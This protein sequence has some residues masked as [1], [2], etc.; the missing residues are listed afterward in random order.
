VQRL[1]DLFTQSSYG[2]GAV[3]V[4]VSEDGDLR[5]VRISRG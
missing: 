2:V 3:E 5:K 4:D 1:R